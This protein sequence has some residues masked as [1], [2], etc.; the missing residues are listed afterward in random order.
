VREKVE[1]D[2]MIGELDDAGLFWR[3]AERFKN[4]D[5]HREKIDDPTM[6]TIVEELIGKF[7]EA[8][9]ENPGE[10]GTPAGCGPLDVDLMPAADRTGS[11]RKASCPRT[12]EPT[13]RARVAVSRPWIRKA[14]LVFH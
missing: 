14:R 12:K 6:G 8:L 11:G 2:T 4:V 13:A 9:S 3:V 7:N 1:L 10:Q 5:L